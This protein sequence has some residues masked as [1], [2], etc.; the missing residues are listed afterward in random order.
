MNVLERPAI[1]SP[2][3]LCSGNYVFLTSLPPRIFSGYLRL[4]RRVDKVW[5]YL[6]SV[7]PCS[8]PFYIPWLIR[9]GTRPN[10][11]TSARTH[12]IFY[13]LY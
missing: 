10:F 5:S 13:A 9:V 3:G 7:Y 12:T 8:P 1:G 6:Q 2:L 4:A 11:L